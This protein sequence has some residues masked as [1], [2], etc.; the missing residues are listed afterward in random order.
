MTAED[1]KIMQDQDEVK[2][3]KFLK[4]IYNKEFYIGLKVKKQFDN[5]GEPKTR[6]TINLVKKVNHS[7]VNEKII[8]ILEKYHKNKL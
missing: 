2:L 1:V 4:T 5:R 6:K 8:E 3:F 7:Q